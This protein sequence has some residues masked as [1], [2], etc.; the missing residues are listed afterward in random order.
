MYLTFFVD[1]G[2]TIENFSYILDNKW[3]RKEPT[4]IKNSLTATNLDIQYIGSNN[5]IFPAL[6]LGVGLKVYPYFLSFIFRIDF[7]MNMLKAIIYQK[8][9]ES[10]QI[11]FS[12]S[13]S[14]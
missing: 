13:D 10:F 14:F 5:Y 6:S 3:Y 2:F 11:V 8:P 4:S 9:E 1:G 12:L 7:A